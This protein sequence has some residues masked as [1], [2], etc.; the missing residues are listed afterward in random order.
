MKISVIVLAK[1]EEERIGACLDAV[2]WADERIVLDNGSTDGTVEVAKK[3]GAKVIKTSS[4]S[5]ADIRNLGRRDAKGEW[6]LYVDAD[7]TVT[8]DLSKEIQ[9]IIKNPHGKIAY[10]LRRKN[11][12]LGK[13]WPYEEK[14]LR[15]F[16]K[17]A[18]KEWFGDLHESAR[19]EGETGELKGVLLHN[20]HRTLE[21]MVAKT[22]EWSETEVILRF[23]SHHPIIVW[24][25]LF[26]VMATAFF[27][28]FIREGGWKAGTIGWIESIYQS[29]S[30]FITY[31]KLWELQQ[32][33]EQS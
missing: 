21:E 5:F 14:I 25:R 22:N 11:Y 20:T 10:A 13:P 3:H 2:S 32:K 9:S 24:W 18:L 4:K 12:Y 33:R 15:L 31:A 16:Q 7:E 8:R 19:V 1:D 30:M 29:F 27:H 28:S 6:I 23:R 17:S 26:R